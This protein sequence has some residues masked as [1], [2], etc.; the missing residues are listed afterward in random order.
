MSVQSRKLSSKIAS[1]FVDNFEFSSFY[2][3]A[4]DHL[5]HESDV[6]TTVSGSEDE[7]F[8]S[9]KNKTIFGKRLTSNSVVR[10]IKNIP[11][12]TGKFE[13]YD[14][15]VDLVG[16]KYYCIVDEGSFYHVYKCLDNN[17]G[18]NSTVQ[19]SF[20]DV[21]LDA[22]YHQTADGYRWKYLCST[23][24]NLVNDAGRSDW[25][26]I[27]S[28]N[29]VSDQA[30]PG[31]IDVVKIENAGAFYN[32]YYT[33]NFALNDI[34]PN[35]NTIQY[36]L[37]SGTPIN[38]FYTGTVLY[39]NSGP[40]EGSWAIV[41]SYT[42]NS[43]GNFVGLDRPLEDIPTNG[44]SFDIYPVVS[45]RMANGSP[46]L[47]RA[48]VNSLAS[49]SV[50]RVEMLDRGDSIYSGMNLSVYASNTV[51]VT[52][53]AIVRPIY[54]PSGG[55]GSNVYEELDAR[56]V[57]VYT[58][59]S[60]TEYSTIPSTN[61]FQQIGIV[62]N[63]KF[64]SVGVMLDSVHG[65]FEIGEKLNVVNQLAAVAN[66]ST[67]MSSNTI[68]GSNT[69][70]FSYQ[71]KA[72]D[73]IMI[74]DMIT[75]NSMISRV[76]SVANNVFM[77]LK[78]PIKFTSN[79]VALYWPR[80]V[81]EMTVSDFFTSTSIEVSNT[82]PFQ[83]PCNVIGKTSGTFGRIISVSRNGE[84][85]AF[86]T[87]VGLRKLDITSSTGTFTQN[88]RVTQGSNT[89]IL[90][91]S[92]SSVIL[93][94]PE[95]GTFSPNLNIVGSLSGVQARVSKVYPRET[96]IDSGNV[97]TVENVQAVSRDSNRTETIKM[98]LEF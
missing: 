5:N 66:C 70:I 90:H 56:G 9:V 22:P 8:I 71:F 15:T 58:K 23:P 38:D 52:N 34:N 67:T 65:T 27:V 64:D 30:T 72:N 91:S 59:F 13:M 20:S 43:S 94:T 16:Q 11:W 76:D 55:H 14:D 1:D 2:V 39:M 97:L 81:Q 17:L 36:A 3:F 60:N 73:E 86:D 37:S 51:G 31:S 19:P 75:G 83:I 87:F 45:G 84:N 92:N 68:T 78:D 50:Y 79:N 93:I 35:G 21:V 41:N 48:F 44:D 4:G 40:A 62:E 26:P 29:V 57:I 10:A 7:T 47:G 6:V 80:P 32:S 95:T 61:K 25:F 49:N 85:K 53:T 54:S 74:S 96:S 77:R 33:G 46:I 12:A 82:L 63:L 88:E 24:V 69:T 98:V 28:N 42:C 18:S 89:A